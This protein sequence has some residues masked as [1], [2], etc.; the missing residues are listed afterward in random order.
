MPEKVEELKKL[1]TKLDAE[2]NE[3][4]RARGEVK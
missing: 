3:N 4:K 1:M 2:I